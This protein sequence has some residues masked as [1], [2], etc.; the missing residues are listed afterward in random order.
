M[1]THNSDY[2]PPGRENALKTRAFRKKLR[3]AED[4]SRQSQPSKDGQGPAP[5]V[6]GPALFDG[7]RVRGRRLRLL[8]DP[9]GLLGLLRLKAI[10]M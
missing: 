1:P 7:R 3:P 4:Q 8:L 10:Q 9:P 2:T 6:P 5:G